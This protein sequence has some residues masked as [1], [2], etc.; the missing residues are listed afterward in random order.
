M[1]WVT[2]TVITDPSN[3]LDNDTQNLSLLEE[4]TRV[5]KVFRPE[6]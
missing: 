4:C 5:V 6:S 2:K 1:W 3:Q